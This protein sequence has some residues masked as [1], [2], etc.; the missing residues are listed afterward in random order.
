M[1]AVTFNAD[2]LALVD[3]STE[4]VT[5]I[6]VGA[7]PAQFYVQ[8]DNRFAYVANQ[9]TEESPS[10]TVSKIDLETKKVAATIETG[11]G[12]HG[13]ITSPDLAQLYVTNIYENALSGY[14][15]Q[16]SDCHSTNRRNVERRNDYTVKQ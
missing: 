14:P 13:L 12:A 6:E 5:K 1:F 3:I 9:G 16:S 7:V 11:D 8:P 4:A 2:I 10:R 15:V